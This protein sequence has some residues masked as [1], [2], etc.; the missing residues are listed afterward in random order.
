M[1]FDTDIEINGA[2]WLKTSR[3]IIMIVREW[4]SSDC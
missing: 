4:M 2:Y 3:D 1:L